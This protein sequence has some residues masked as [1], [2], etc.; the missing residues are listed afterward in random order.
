[1]E[2]AS[3]LVTDG[4]PGI[5]SKGELIKVS[6]DGIH[7]GRWLPIFELCQAHGESRF[8]SPPFGKSI[9]STHSFAASSSGIVVSWRQQAG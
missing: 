4:I 7:I 2:K 8:S 5:A 1:M 3:F 9:F 6:D